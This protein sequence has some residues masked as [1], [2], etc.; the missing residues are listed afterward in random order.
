MSRTA[1][2][3]KTLEQIGAR[4]RAAREKAGMTGEQLAD[5]SGISGQDA[6]AK[7]EN[8]DRACDI[9]K[10]AALAKALGV[11]AD[12]LL[13]G[14]GEMERH[15]TMRDCCQFLYKVMPA[16]FDWEWT[17]TWDSH[18]SPLEGKCSENSLPQIKFTLTLPTERDYEFDFEN[19]IAVST[20]YSHVAPAFQ[21]LASF[22][23]IADTAQRALRKTPWLIDNAAFAEEFTKIPQTHIA[24]LK[25]AYPIP[26]SDD[27]FTIPNPT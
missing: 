11:T 10:L 16:C 13:F 25:E 24:H 1:E 21:Y 22:A 20:G 9:L 8:A 14:D 2:E 4:I 7:Y 19:E 6:I 15:M 3:Q 26:P 12:W 5:K 18:T 23:E 27:D 17:T